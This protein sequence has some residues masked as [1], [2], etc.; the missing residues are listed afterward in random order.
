M[1]VY[2]FTRNNALHS[3]ITS[4]LLS[5]VVRPAGNQGLKKV[6]R[7]IMTD[8]NPVLIIDEEF[9]REG[10]FPLLEYLISSQIPGPK[11]L[12]PGRTAIQSSYTS[13]GKVA[14]LYRPFTADQLYRCLLSLASRKSLHRY[15]PV[16]YLTDVHPDNV[17]GADLL[18]GKSP[19]M[20]VIRETIATVGTRFHAIHISGET[21]SGKEVAADLIA[22]SFNDTTHVERVNCSAIPS[23]LAD[24][25]LFGS[26]KGSYTGS[27]EDRRGCI[28]RADGGILFLDEIEDLPYESQGKLLRVLE[29]GTYLPLGSEKLQ[30]SRFRLISAS[31]TDLRKMVS[32]KQFRI[33]LYHRIAPLTI[34]LPP[35][36]ERIEDIPLL[37][38][39]YLKKVQENRSVAQETLR[40]LMEHPWPGNVRE[41]FNTVEQLRLFSP[42][43]A[44]L[45]LAHH[46]EGD[47][48]QKKF[49]ISS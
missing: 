10:L 29:T 6:C 24:A 37:I 35:L 2:L 14:I 5:P 20:R 9:H 39:S 26:I 11:L 44:P 16:S 19:G 27:V 21:G 49:L 12:I 23:T 38:D 41:L 46:P 4:L 31:N 15:I 8:R 36:R 42:P 43:E 47:R 32:T 13:D 25:F 48:F 28:G 40:Q 30:T 18:V 34:T 3:E 17:S 1:A 33:D 45:S 7:S 22:E